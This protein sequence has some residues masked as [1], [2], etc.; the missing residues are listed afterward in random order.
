MRVEERMF[1]EDRL[2]AILRFRVQQHLSDSS[3]DKS[4]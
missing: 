2:N 3:T 1:L 4:F